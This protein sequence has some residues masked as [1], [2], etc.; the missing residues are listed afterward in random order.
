MSALSPTTI[1]RLAG[2]MATR[3]GQE[4]REYSASL[5]EQIEMATVAGKFGTNDE[6]REFGLSLA[7]SLRDPIFWQKVDT[8][9]H[10]SFR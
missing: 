2:Q 7:A 9:L 1:H 6:G 5:A 3:N 8:L 10:Y 4:S